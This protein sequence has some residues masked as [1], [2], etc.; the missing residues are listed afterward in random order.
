MAQDDIDVRNFEMSGFLGDLATLCAT[1]KGW[2]AKVGIVI[3]I[4]EGNLEAKLPIIWTDG[5]KHHSHG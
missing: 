2:D 5:K 4:V 1:C 3:F